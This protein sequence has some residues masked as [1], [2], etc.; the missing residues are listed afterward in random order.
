MLKKKKKNFHD[1]ASWL[2][3]GVCFSPLLVVDMFD[4]FF[5]PM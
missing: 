2:V 3:F 5:K 1:F 4:E